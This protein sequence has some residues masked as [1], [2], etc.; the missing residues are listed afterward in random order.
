M[1][2]TFTSTNAFFDGTSASSP[3]FAGMISL[4]N[5]K[6]LNEGANP[7]GP[8]NP[9]LY[10]VRLIFLVTIKSFIHNHPTVEFQPQWWDSKLYS[11]HCNIK[12]VEKC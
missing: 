6:L 1:I 10:K 4:I 2:L 9:L 5:N 7:I 11:Y 8:L 3:A 12:N